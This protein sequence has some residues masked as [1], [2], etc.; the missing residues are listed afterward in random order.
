MPFSTPLIFCSS[1]VATAASTSPAAAPTNVVVTCTIGGT[2]SGYC[3][4]GSPCIATSPS[5][6][7]MMD[8]TIATMG[9]STKNLAMG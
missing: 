5:I 7:M 2:I 8:N 1:G 3:A 9:R 4:I 6:T